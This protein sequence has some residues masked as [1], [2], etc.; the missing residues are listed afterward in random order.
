MRE[1]IK[2]IAKILLVA[3][4]LF[5]ALAF[6]SEK[7]FNFIKQE[8]AEENCYQGTEIAV[9]QLNGKIVPY[10][11]N[12]DEAETSSAEFVSCLELIKEDGF[13]EGVVIEISSYGG[14]PYAST[15]I[16]NAI[17]NMGKPT[18]AVIRESAASGGYL[19]ASATDRIF[20]N[21]VS[22]IGGIGVTMSYLDYSQKNKKEGIV[23]HE[24]STAKFKNY[25]DPDK[26]LTSEEK[27]LIMR[28]LKIMH[29]AF[30]KNVSKNRGI[31]IEK[32][33]KLADGSTMLGKMAKE[34]GLIDEMGDTKSAKAW[35]MGMQ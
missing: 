30:V 7:A 16:M 12:E 20:A 17:K 15:E 26:P 1:K 27:E 3:F 25:G 35:L 10:F 2:R 6:W 28:D 34:N 21:E 32:V 22:E 31:E 18:V 4:V 8:I 13:I 29:E 5:T 19:I 33:E 9:L 24:L 14:S 11:T 23:F